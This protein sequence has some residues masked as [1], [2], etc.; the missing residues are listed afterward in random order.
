MT[1]I[2]CEYGL[3]IC[4]KIKILIALRSPYKACVSRYKH[5]VRRGFENQSF[6]NA[7]KLWPERKS[8]DYPWDFDYLGA[9]Q[10]YSQ[11]QAYIDNFENVKVVLLDEYSQ[12]PVI[13]YKEILSFLR[14]TYCSTIGVEYMHIS[15]PIEKKWFRERMEKKENQL[16][17]NQKEIKLLEANQEIKDIELNNQQKW[18][19]ILTFGFVL[20]M[21]LLLFVFKQ[22]KSK[23]KAYKILVEKNL[24]IVSSEKIKKLEVKKT[25]EVS[26]NKEEILPKESKYA[27]SQLSELQKKQLLEAILLHMEDDKPYLEKSFNIN[28]LAKKLNSSRSYV[29]QVINEELERNFN[30]FINEYRIKEARQMLSVPENKI[31]TIESIAF[32]VGFGSK[33]SFNNA[34]K[35][36]TGITPSFY[37]KSLS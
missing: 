31:L 9:F 4:N 19:S 29:S 21:F 34:F 32:S 17:L 30:Q 13:S 36:Y 26:N 22:M 33:S 25:K 28:I 35:N 10:Y 24:E 2:W 3:T 27:D 14:K 20:V 11:V 5:S 8:L 6:S 7:I 23:N 18:L 1:T 12:N 16:E 15:D 37:L